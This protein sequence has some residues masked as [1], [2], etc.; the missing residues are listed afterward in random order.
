[1]SGPDGPAPGRRVLTPPRA[2]ALGLTLVGGAAVFAW[3]LHAVRNGVWWQAGVA[4]VVWA[5]HAVVV[6]RLWRV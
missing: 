2:V 4:A 5:L 3:T 1:M 6:T